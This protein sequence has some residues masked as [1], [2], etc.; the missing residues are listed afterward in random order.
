MQTV[1]SQLLEKDDK[2]AL[3]KQ[4]VKELKEFGQSEITKR[5]GL[6]AELKQQKSSEEVSASL[7][8][9][10]EQRAKDLE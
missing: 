4:K 7:N 1:Q 9:E 2:L 10:A 6:E 8:R 3:K 5:E